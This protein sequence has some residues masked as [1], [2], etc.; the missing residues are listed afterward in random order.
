MAAD[1][2]GGATTAAAISTGSGFVVDEAEQARFLAN[3][4]RLVWRKRLLPVGAVILL[5]VLW[6][7]AVIQF[8]IKP[9]VVE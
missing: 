3:K 6:H 7:W 8:E 1:I 9:F 5:L 2:A 4:R